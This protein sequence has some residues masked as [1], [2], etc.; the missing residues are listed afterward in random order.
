[1][2]VQEKYLP[3]SRWIR[4]RASA[5]SNLLGDK[6]LNI[7]KGRDSRTVKNGDGIRSLQAQDIPELMAQSAN[8]L[9]SFQTIVNRVDS[10]LAGVEAGQGQ[11][12]QAIQGRGTVQSPERDREPKGSSCSPMCAMATA[13]SAS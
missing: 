11:Y 6:F 5:P 1:M 10:L 7:T 9:Q 13:R 3:R 8:L 4:W 12:R 2:K